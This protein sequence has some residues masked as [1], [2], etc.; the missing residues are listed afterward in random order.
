MDRTDGEHDDNLT[1]R[2]ALKIIVSSAGATVSLPVLGRS[3]PAS[4]AAPRCHVATRAAESPA[5]APRYFGAQQIRTL[6]AV[7]ETIIPA[8]EHSPGAK[9][10][11]VWEYIDDIVADSN[12]S[13]KRFWTEGLVAIDKMAAAEYGKS[14]SECPAE[15]QI[16][17]L[18]KIS[19]NE[20]HPTTR[21]EKFFAGIKKA[22]VDG[23]YTSA[24]GIHQELEYQG[25]TALAE[26]PGCTH[27][28]HKAPS[29]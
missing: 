23:Y 29:S 11:R 15:Q 16:A 25:N 21:E 4:G 2:K 22:T 7:S 6:E 18:E 17:L 8:D 14:F 10:A 9:A 5:H 27:E 28:E 19:R 3:A 13:T 20:A 1:R 12:E 24:I 26:F